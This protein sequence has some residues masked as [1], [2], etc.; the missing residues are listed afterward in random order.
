[1]LASEY[2]NEVEDIDFE[3]LEDPRGYLGMSSEI[4]RDA[5][6]R[7]QNQLGE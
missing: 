5:A 1:M 4:S 2:A 6:K 3:A 7:F